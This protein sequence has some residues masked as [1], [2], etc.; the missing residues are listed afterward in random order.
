LDVSANTVLTTLVCNQNDLVSLD[1][2]SNTELIELKCSQN[3]LTSLDVS[4]NPALTK[5]ECFINNLMSLDVS[6]NPALT[7]LKCYSSHL[8]YLNIKNGNNT[9]ILDIFF[10]ATNN[11]N[12]TCILVDDATWSA[13]NWTSIDAQMHFV[14]SQAECDA[15]YVDETDL[16]N[17]I[18]IYPNP[19]K[20][21]L[22]I[23]NNSNET[24]TEITM[25]SVLGKK[26][27]SS[28][29]IQNTID[30]RNLKSGL[31]LLKIKSN[32]KSVIKK[33][34]ISK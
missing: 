14:N 11:P 25:Y 26:V 27:Y 4:A 8:S 18:I 10:N 29:I 17:S 22:N 30:I 5:L 16:E 23:T 20:N 33:I 15:L 6:A 21:V 1:V 31:Y 12:L 2:S 13:N 7:T 34:V 28:L 3:N 19:A 24:I 32:D 9:A